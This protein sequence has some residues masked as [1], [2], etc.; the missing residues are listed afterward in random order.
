MFL[1]YYLLSSDKSFKD[2]LPKTNTQKYEECIRT[3]KNIATNGIMYYG[4]TDRD[5]SKT[6]VQKYK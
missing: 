2:F 4:D 3:C 6:C 5:R 1:G